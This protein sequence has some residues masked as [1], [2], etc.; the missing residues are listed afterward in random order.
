MR[1]RFFD[2]D[3]YKRCGPRGA[4]GVKTKRITW[5]ENGV[6][7]EVEEEEEEVK[8]TRCAF[9]LKMHEFQSTKFCN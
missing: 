8:K 5:V 9:I 6:G 3:E 4:F 7:E 2:C 1:F